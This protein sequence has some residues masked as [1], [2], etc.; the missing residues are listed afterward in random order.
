MDSDEKART[1]QGM[2]RDSEMSQRV[3]GIDYED[4]QVRQA[5][6]HTREDLVLVY[7]HLSDITKLL[8]S[9]YKLLVI[10]AVAAV[11]S[12]VALMW[13]LLG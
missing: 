7:S 13:P 5:V 8:G 3:D 9:I 12:A 6:V 11:V 4:E 10:I 1:L 2:V